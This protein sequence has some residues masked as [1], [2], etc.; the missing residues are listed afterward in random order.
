MKIGDGITLVCDL[1]FVEE[2]LTGR[3]DEVEADMANHVHS[4]NDLQDKPFGEIDLH[5]S[6]DAATAAT[7][8]ATTVAGSR[9]KF[10]KICDEF[11]TPEQALAAGMY[12]ESST[13]NLVDGGWSVSNR[14]FSIYEK[15]V[16]L[17]FST[18][19]TTF[20]STG[21]YIYGS[22]VCEYTV[23]GYSTKFI[24]E[25]YIPDTIARVADL[26]EIATV[27]DYQFLSWLNNENMVEPITSAS[28]EIYTTNN[29]EIYIL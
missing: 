13:A 1:P 14:L 6:I 22:A 9:N 27:S 25:N 3:L 20:E 26:P 28:G 23:P 11:L 16:T 8:P 17:A 4:W 18:G 15:T 5:I 19:A 24:D 29:N 10:Y 21:T 12:N 2:A 7:I